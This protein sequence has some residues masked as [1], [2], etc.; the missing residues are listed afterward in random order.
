MIHPSTGFSLV[1]VLMGALDL[2]T[3][4]RRGVWAGEGPDRI[5]ADAYGAVWSP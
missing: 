1:R 2:C 4:I 5:A 3:A